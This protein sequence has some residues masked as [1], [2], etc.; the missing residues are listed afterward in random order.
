MHN[1]DEHMFIKQQ[2]TALCCCLFV[3]SVYCC[4]CL[5]LRLLVY[6]FCLFLFLFFVC[7]FLSVF[8]CC[9]LRC[10]LL[11]VCCLSFIAAVCLVVAARINKHQNKSDKQT[12]AIEY[13]HQNIQK[14]VCFYCCCYSC[15]CFR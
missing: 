3:V 2:E 1:R 5:L 11:F 10:I 4:F 9:C 7:R 6:C 8:F 12:A 14:T 13:E 15:F